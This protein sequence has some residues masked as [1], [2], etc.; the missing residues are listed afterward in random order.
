MIKYKRYT[1]VDGIP[2][3]VI[4]DENERII[5]KYPCGDELKCLQIEKYKTKNKKNI[6]HQYTDNELL[7][8]L[9]LFVEENERIPMQ[10]DFDNDPRYPGSKTYYMHFGSWNNALILA[11][12]SIRKR[13]NKKVYT[14]EEL[15]NFLKTF[16]EKNNRVPTKDDF[17]NNSEYPNCGTYRKRFGSWNNALK[18]VGMDMDTTIKKGYWPNNVSKGRWFEIIIIEMFGNKSIDLSGKNRHN[19][20]DGICPNGQIYDAKSARLDI[21]GFWHFTTRSKDKDDDKEAIQW[22]YF[23]AFNKDFTELLYVWRVPGEIVEDDH[24]YVG[25][26]DKF[27][28][29]LENMKGYDITDE[30]KKLLDIEQIL[31]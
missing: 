31:L 5:N 1:I 11:G 12:L 8:L 17:T 25:T 30:F 13:D 15:L 24:F 9:K 4:V 7:N 29:N 21:M 10:K 20:C 6:K 2:G 16:Y 27:K 19:Y 3:W 26:R 22:Y 28:F 18:Q 14:E 23:G